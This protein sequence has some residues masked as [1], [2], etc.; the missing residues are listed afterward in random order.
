[1]SVSRTQCI[2]AVA[3]AVAAPLAAQGRAVNLTG[4]P[5]VALEE[6]FTQISAVRELPGNRAVVVD[7]AEK[8]VQMADFAKGELTKISRNGGGPGEYQLPLSAFTAPNNVT[9]VSDP[10]IGKIHV[11]TPDGKITSTLLTPENNEERLPSPRGAD[12]SGRFYFQGQGIRADAQGGVDSVPIL[13]WDPH[14]KRIDSIAWIPLGQATFARTAGNGF[15]FVSRTTKPYS[16]S[17]AW[18]VL[19]DGRIAIVRTEPYRVD[20]ADGYGHTRQGPTIRYAPVR[21]GAAER[22]AYRKDLQSG[23]GQAQTAFRGFSNGPSGG[24]TPAA[25]T[26]GPSR[27]VADEDFPPQMPAF[28]AGGVHITPEG[29]VWVLRNRAASDKTPTYDI[30]DSSGT[31]VGKATLK[32]NST[33]VGFGAGTVYVAR[34]DPEDDLRYLEKY[35]R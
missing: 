20:I 7:A 18:G 30:F 9:Y 24:S 21:I 29:E 33:V 31:L 28:S 1:M 23:Q 25:A 8:T 12:L 35:T 15:N 4:K 6:P 16:S 5:A 26:R 14:A 19:P 34:Q 22:E 2:V 3:F 11:V 13:R 32:P 17:D 10:Q 27:T